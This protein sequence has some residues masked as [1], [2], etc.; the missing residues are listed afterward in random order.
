MNRA[1]VLQRAM[2]AAVLAFAFSTVVGT[3]VLLAQQAA[4]AAVEEHARLGVRSGD[5]GG[6]EQPGAWLGDRSQ[7]DGTKYASY[8]VEQKEIDAR[9][10]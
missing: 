4:P 6:E 1:G 8:I 5:Q 2:V 7:L 3:P 9:L 10:G